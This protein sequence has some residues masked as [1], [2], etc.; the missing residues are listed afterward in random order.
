MVIKN[1]SLG[2]AVSVPK[3][4]GISLIVN[5]V[6]TILLSIFISVMI[7][8]ERITWE[9]SGYWIMIMLLLSSFLGAKAAIISI[10]T[11]T[12]LTAFMSGI[13]YWGALLCST[14]LFFGGNYSSVFE[15]AILIAAGSLT[16]AM[17][18][19][20]TRGSKTRIQRRGYC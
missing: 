14:G 5:A 19:I 1:N 16:A 20:P 17:I 12:L 15:T 7:S 8:Q 6:I 13:L 10:K 9:A 11:Q 3:G 18:N 4:L 2:K